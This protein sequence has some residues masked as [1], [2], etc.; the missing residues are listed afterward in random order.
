MGKKIVVG[1]FL[2]VLFPAVLFLF[3]QNYLAVNGDQGEKQTQTQKVEITINNHQNK[4]DGGSGDRKEKT[5][6]TV[7]TNT[8]TTG[9]SVGTPPPPPPPALPPDLSLDLGGTWTG[10]WEN[11][12]GQSGDGSLSVKET[13]KGALVGWLD[14]DYKVLKGKRVNQQWI[15]FE[16]KDSDRYYT[17]DGL[18]ADRGRTLFVF[19][20]AIF[21]DGKTM[22][23]IGFYRL[24]R[25]GVQAFSQPQPANWSGRWVGKWMNSLGFTG[26]DEIEITDN[27]NGTIGGTW[28]GM[29]I[30]KGVKVNDR[31]AYF[32]MDGTPVA[33]EEDRHYTVQVEWVSPTLRL[34]HTATFRPGSPRK[35]Y[36]GTS[37]LVRA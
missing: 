31:T 12:R 15:Y 7:P 35:A 18:V 9:G 34:T 32:E 4:D 5:H 14:R 28:C 11:T 24:A 20:D 19:Y 37:W 1:L 26:S 23:Y 2:G 8:G 33:N 30:R 27:G 36:T 6:T 29:P 25:E 10:T 13:Q 17:F 22:P 21:D 16:A 3:K